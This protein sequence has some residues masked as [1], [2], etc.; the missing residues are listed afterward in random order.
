MHMSIS[1][2]FKVSRAFV[3][4]QKIEGG[5]KLVRPRS[6]RPGWLRQHCETSSGLEWAGKCT[7]QTQW[8]DGVNTECVHLTLICGTSCLAWLYQIDSRG[9]SRRQRHASIDNVQQLICYIIRLYIY[10]YNI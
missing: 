5:E 7:G 3:H 8:M 9:F 1:S 10:I 2:K 4:A 6:G